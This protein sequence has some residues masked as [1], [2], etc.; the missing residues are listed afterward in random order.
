M[1]K[2]KKTRLVREESAKCVQIFGKINQTGKI[3]T[4]LRVGAL[5]S[6]S[7]SCFSRTKELLTYKQKFWPAALFSKQKKNYKPMIRLRKINS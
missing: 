1:G 5:K 2:E 7:I 3:Y 6:S 4:R